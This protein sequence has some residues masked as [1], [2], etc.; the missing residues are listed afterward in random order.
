MRRVLVF[1]A[2][3]S[4][5]LPAD[6][7]K[8]P[9]R[10]TAP[11]ASSGEDLGITTLHFDPAD[12]QILSAHYTLLTAPARD[13]KTRLASLVADNGFATFVVS[14]WV[15]DAALEMGQDSQTLGAAL[16]SSTG[17]GLLSPNPLVAG[18]LVAGLSEDRGTLTVEYL[19]KGKLCRKRG[20][21]GTVL[22]L[23]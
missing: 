2:L 3:Y 12:I 10:S 6:A 17:A 15:C 19:Y 5:V 20:D 14:D 13:A 21:Y 23:P 22:V 7:G 8:A 9:K 1:L 16:G 11:A 4:C 18:S